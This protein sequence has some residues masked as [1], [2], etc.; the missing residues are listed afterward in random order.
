MLT[1]NEC[2]YDADKNLNAIELQTKYIHEHPVYNRERLNAADVDDV[3][4][5]KQVYTSIHSRA[6]KRKSV[7]KPLNMYVPHKVYKIMHRVHG[8]SLPITVSELKTGKVEIEGTLQYMM[9][10]SGYKLPS[11]RS[12]TVEIL[13][14]CS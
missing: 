5:W 9:Y 3:T 13:E 6:N 7:S 12:L 4:Y 11:D 1:F 8:G 10:Y 14:K 2:N